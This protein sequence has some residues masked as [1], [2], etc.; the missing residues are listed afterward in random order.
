[1]FYLSYKD[2]TFNS[3]LIC[4]QFIACL[5]LYINWF[6]QYN[7]KRMVSPGCYVISVVSILISFSNKLDIII[8]LLTFLS[9]IYFHPTYIALISVCN[10]LRSYYAPLINVAYLYLIIPLTTTQCMYFLLQNSMHV[11]YAFWHDFFI[12]TLS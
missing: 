8:I 10:V 11:F 7:N 6:I 4:F 5:S 3:S 12:S 1:M 9:L 2:I